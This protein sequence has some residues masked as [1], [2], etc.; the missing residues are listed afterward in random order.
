MPWLGLFVVRLAL[1]D[2]QP[3]PLSCLL[4]PRHQHC[5][6]RQ[7]RQVFGNVDAGL[8]QLQQFDLL[9][10]LASDLPDFF[11]P[12][13]LGEWPR[14]VYLVPLGRRTLVELVGRDLNAVVPHCSACATHQS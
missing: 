8:V 13:K 4:Q 3:R 11:G 1:L 9:A 10:L 6:W 2:L 5:T 14:L 12:F 7:G